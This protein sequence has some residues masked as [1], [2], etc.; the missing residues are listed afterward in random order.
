[1]EAHPEVM[2]INLESENVHPKVWRLLPGTIEDH[3]GPIETHSGA[4]KAHPGAFKACPGAVE[5]HLEP[6]KL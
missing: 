4:F 3:P 2:Q 1:M 5:D 6:L